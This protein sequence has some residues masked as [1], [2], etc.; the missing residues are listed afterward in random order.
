MMNVSVRAA[1]Y[2]VVR[3]LFVVLAAASMVRGDWEA[4]AIAVIGLALSI[5][6]QLVFRK[7]HLKLPLL[8]ELVIIG[9]VVASLMLGELFDAYSKFWW[10]DS[11][12]HLSSGVLIGYIGFMILFTLQVQGRLKVSAAMV[13]FLTF[14]VSMMVAAMWEVVEFTID[15]VYGATMQHGNTDTMKDIILAMF[16]SLLATA[17]AYWHHR[18]PEKSPLRGELTKFFRENKHLTNKRAKTKR[19]P[20]GDRV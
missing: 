20:G 2:V 8:Y 16:G 10:W 13:A 11:A 4:A 14:S 15:E 9:F 12:L 5:L 19:L 1:I 17:A 6:P 18:W 7:Y 3:T